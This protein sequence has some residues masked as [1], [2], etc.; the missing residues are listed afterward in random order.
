MPSRRTGAIVPWVAALALAVLLPATA[1]AA[2]P[3]STY[4]ARVGFS[5]T[6]DQLVLGAFGTVHKFTPQVSFRP[7]GDLGIGN[8]VLTLIA[9]L[10]VQYT[11]PTS[12]RGP[13]PFF[14]GGLGLLWYDP[15]G[16]DSGTDI[17]LQLYGGVEIAYRGYQTGV[18]EVRVGLDDR[19]P[20][21]KLTYGFGFY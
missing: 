13:V 3:L 19:M 2:G 4:G 1:G 18:I 17:G 8:S 6:P 15:D 10:D 21:F 20:D 16:G 11:F 5:T 12:G 9:N 7:S 14:G